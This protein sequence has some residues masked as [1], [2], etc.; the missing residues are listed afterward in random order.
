VQEADK[1]SKLILMA[2]DSTGNLYKYFLSI[3][4]MTIKN[5]FAFLDAWLLEFQKKLAATLALAA[6]AG[7]AGGAAY[8]PAGLAP[9]LAKIGVKPGYGAGIKF[10]TDNQAS[11]DLGNGS[12]GLQTGSSNWVDTSS[13]TG[14]G[15]NVQVV[16]QGNVVTEQDLIDAIQKGLQTNSLSGSPSAIGRIAGMFG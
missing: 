1:L 8:V 14:K 5:P 11:I 6:G 7:G 15:T 9:E 10:S 12:Y 2:Q 16:V 4:D 13:I 3:G